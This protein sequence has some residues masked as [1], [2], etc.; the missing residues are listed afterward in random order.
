M[1]KLRS[2]AAAVVALVS[3]V[4]AP[5]VASA[6]A[7][8][9]NPSQSLSSGLS[10]AEVQAARSTYPFSIGTHIYVGAQLTRNAKGEAPVAFGA[11]FEGMW[12]GTVGVAT[13]ILSVAGS[14]LK[15]ATETMGVAE[16]VP[17]DRI[18]VPIVLA[19]RP[20][21][22]MGWKKTGWSSRLSSAWELQA[23]PSVEHVRQAYEGKT[24]AALHLGTSLDI[25]L[26]LGSAVEGGVTLQLFARAVVAPRRTLAEGTLESRTFTGQIY[27]GFCWYP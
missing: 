24:V 10:G 7:W 11:M 17:A 2:Y 21:Q 13:G 4:V 3:V 14:R 8:P 23:G 15:P 12:R 16:P 1:E 9:T 5:A 6:Q 18:S 20:L 25:P 27:A 19:I 26:Y 22:P